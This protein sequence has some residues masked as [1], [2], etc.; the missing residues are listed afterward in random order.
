MISMNLSMLY[1]FL[2]DDVIV[3]SASS[4]VDIVDNIKKDENEESVCKKLILIPTTTEALGD[5]LIPVVMTIINQGLIGW[6]K[7]LS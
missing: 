6:P 4:V 3:A 5:I 2:D 1:T 7:M